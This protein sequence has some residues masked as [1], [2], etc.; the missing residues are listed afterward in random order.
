MYVIMHVILYVCNH[1]LNYTFT[2]QSVNKFVQ[3][4]WPH[5]LSLAHIHWFIKLVW[6]DLVG[7]TLTYFMSK[8]SRN[9]FKQC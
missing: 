6:H 2:K 7:G 5:S 8:E 1:I 9:S 3:E 4:T